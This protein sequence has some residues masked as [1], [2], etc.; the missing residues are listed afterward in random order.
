M[1]IVG[2]V[3]SAAALGACATLSPLSRIEARLIEFGFSRPMA[4][5]F[6]DGLGD[7]L[8]RRQLDGVAD[9][10]DGFENDRKPE[11]AIERLGRGAGNPEIAGAI[12][13]TAFSC[14]IGRGR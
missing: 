11:Q 9:L 3:I 5:C 14:A 13:S 4:E 12:A 2:I 8:D 1:R 7:K 6:A 10:L